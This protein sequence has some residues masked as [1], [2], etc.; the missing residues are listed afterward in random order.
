MNLQ[1]NHGGIKIHE[2]PEKYIQN[3]ELK[4]SN[5][6]SDSEDEDERTTLAPPKE[7]MWQY[8]IS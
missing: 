4:V 1:S 7:V 6:E 3:G 2:I 5:N 8:Y